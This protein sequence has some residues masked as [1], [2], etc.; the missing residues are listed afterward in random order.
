MASKHVCPVCVIQI[1]QED[2]SI[3]CENKCL[4]F[5]HQECVK[6]S[7]TD[8]SRYVNPR[9][10]ENYKWVCRRDDC[11]KKDEQSL[12]MILK[13]LNLITNNISVLSSK[14]DTLI[15]LPD[16]VDSLITEVETLNGN[17][18]SLEQRVT[19][20]ESKIE[21][22]EKQFQTVNNNQS[23][24]D[25]EATISEI[26]E[27]ERRSKNIIIYNLPE[28]KSNTTSIRIDHDTR[29]IA[30][31]IASFCTSEVDASFKSYRIG[32]PSKDNSR[33]LKV[34][35]K[36]S[37]AVIEF[38]KNFDP[39]ILDH[40]EPDLRKVSISRDRTPMER[41]YLQDLRAELKNRTDNG[42]V[43]LTIKYINGTPQIIKIPSKND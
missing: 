35:L 13:Q 15:S 34:I 27:R 14:V 10:S 38:C 43:D 32:R 28:S 41:K 12:S 9:T 25:T 22:L 2:K 18:R 40:L 23:G 16:K 6:L 39:S 21:N 3:Q 37:D 19:F 24:S 42:E 20:T 29:H 7:N 31:L 8:Y 11:M 33:P 5:F 36:N 26:N 17:L 30:K 4:R 1:V